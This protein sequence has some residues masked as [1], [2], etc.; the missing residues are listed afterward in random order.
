M[1]GGNDS[2]GLLEHLKNKTR[3]WTWTEIPY[4]LSPPIVFHFFLKD[5]LIGG[6]HGCTV[7]TAM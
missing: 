1:Q 3:W 5:S 4:G 6:C 2:F 7:C